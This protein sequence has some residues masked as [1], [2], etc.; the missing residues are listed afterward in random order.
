MPIKKKNEIDFDR[1]KSKLKKSIK[2]KIGCKKSIFDFYTF[3]I[4]LTINSKFEFSLSYK[5]LPAH[6]NGKNRDGRTQKCH[7]CV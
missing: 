3:F 2:L 5:N 7:I 6:T 1:F 4:K